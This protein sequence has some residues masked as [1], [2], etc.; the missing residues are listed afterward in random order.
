MKG[1]IRLLENYSEKKHIQILKEK[2]KEEHFNWKVEPIYSNNWADFENEKVPYEI[3]T[4]V[5]DSYYHIPQRPDLAFSFCWQAINNSYN[6]FLLKDT[7]FNKLLS[8]TEGIKALISE[9]ENGYEAKYKNI[10]KPYYD[11]LPD[12]LCRYVASFFLKGYAIEKMNGDKKFQSS[13]YRTF[14]KAYESLSCDLKESYGESYFRI[15]NPEIV[16]GKLKLGIKIE[17]V[18]KSKKIIYSL[19][20]KLKTLVQIGEVE[21]TSSTL[22]K[23][24]NQKFESKDRIEFLL[25]SILY[26]SRCQNFH[27]NVASRLGSIYSDNNSYLAYRY[28]YLLAHTILGISLNINGYLTDLE[29]KNLEKNSNI[30]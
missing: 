11:K 15:L 13:G 22:S 12:K 26:A 1:I 29:I 10:L 17:D 2:I 8:D 23:T 7:Q 27:G 20:Q 4:H 19:S 25:K 14:C 30:L 28:V 3:A 6:E 21:F 18:D 24:Y 5:I 16:D 9:I